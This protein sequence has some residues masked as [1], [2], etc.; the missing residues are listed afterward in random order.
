MQNQQSFSH[1]L[2]YSVAPEYFSSLHLSDDESLEFIHADENSVEDKKWLA[3]SKIDNFYG[4]LINNAIKEQ[5]EQA[6]RWEVGVGAGTGKFSDAIADKHSIQFIRGRE[7]A[8]A[9]EIELDF[10]LIGDARAVLERFSMDTTVRVSLK[11]VGGEGKYMFDKKSDVRDL[12]VLDS[13]LW[14]S[15]EIYTR[16]EFEDIYTQISKTYRF[17]NQDYPQH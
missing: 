6:G 9:G 12:H 8:R 2:L 3:K 1:N 10:E 7:A 11:T 16:E 5:I 15:M 14:N 13:D 4:Q 17:L